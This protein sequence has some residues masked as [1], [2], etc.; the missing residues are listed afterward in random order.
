[1]RGVFSVGGSIQSLPRGDAGLY[2]SRHPGRWTPIDHNNESGE[3]PLSPMGRGGGSDPLPPPTH[4]DGGRG[5]RPIAPSPHKSPM[6]FVQKKNQLKA[7]KKKHREKANSWHWAAGNKTGLL[8][9]NMSW[10]RRQ[11][12][13]PHPCWVM[14]Y[15]TRH[16]SKHQATFGALE[17]A[18]R[19][20][21]HRL[22][23]TRFKSQQKR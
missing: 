14:V 20:P 5:D 13:Q 9:P 15:R 18:F 22:E 10:G 21:I 6:R 3:F 23:L 7:C 8:L 17:I 12:V 11:R 1:M 2:W 16:A 19:T 4:Q